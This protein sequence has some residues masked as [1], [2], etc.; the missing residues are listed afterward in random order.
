MS[1]GLKKTLIE[2]RTLFDRLKKS[3]VVCPYCGYKHYWYRQEAIQYK[4]GDAVLI[5]CRCGGLYEVYKS[6]NGALCVR[7]R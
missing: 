5:E 7:G 4:G 2:R 1:R 6:Q 3:D